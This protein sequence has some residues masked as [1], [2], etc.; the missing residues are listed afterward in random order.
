MD[1]HTAH[2]N[3]QKN[4]IHLLVHHHQTDSGDRRVA[5]IPHMVREKEGG[6]RN[7]SGD[8]T[9]YTPSHADQCVQGGGGGKQRGVCDWRD[10]G[11]K[12]FL[13]AEQTLLSE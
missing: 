12:A 5:Q 10:G 13:F 6:M 9:C 4:N 1:A 7:K 3:A 8:R 2:R 11:S